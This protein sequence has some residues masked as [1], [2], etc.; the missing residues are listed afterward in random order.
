MKRRLVAAI[1]CRN[2]GTRLY[3][4]AIQNIDVENEI[5]ILDN[6]IYCLKTIKQIDAIVLGISDNKDNEVYKDVAKK[7][8]ISFILG[9]EKNVLG[10]L[11]KCGEHESASDIFR[12]T[13]E[14][15]FLYY[16]AI[17]ETWE[18]YNHKKLDAIF[19]DYLIDGIG[20]EIISLDAL[21]L[22]NEKGSEKHRSEFCSLYIRANITLFKVEKITPPNYLIRNDLRLTVDNPEDLVICRRIYKEFQHL[23]P[24]I[25][26]KKIIEFLDSHKDL[27]KLVSPYLEDGYSTMYI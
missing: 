25:E 1:A 10:R 19:M 7:H 5:S 2:Q 9:E 6:I 23:A 26:I 17:E 13:S 21:K 12:I 16:E 22:S 14:C 3:G 15:P 8:K 27:K 24:R 18:R 20:F 11:I 4:K